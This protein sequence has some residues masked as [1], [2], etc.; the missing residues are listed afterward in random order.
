MPMAEAIADL[1]L[2]EVVRQGLL[3]RDSKLGRLVQ[4]VEAME[5]G[6]WE[7]I[8]ALIEPLAH[9][10]VPSLY[11]QAIFWADELELE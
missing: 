11:M 3:Q 7:R 9:L 8:E 4:L 10:N 1:S 2:P 5:L 6:D